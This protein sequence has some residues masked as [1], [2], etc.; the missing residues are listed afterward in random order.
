MEQQ[1]CCIAQGWQTAAYRQLI[2]RFRW[3]QH[4]NLAL[5]QQALRHSCLH[6]GLQHCRLLGVGVQHDRHATGIQSDQVVSVCLVLK[7]LYLLRR[8]LRLAHAVSSRL[9][10]AAPASAASSEMAVG[11]AEGP[12]HLREGCSK[13]Q[14]RRS[15]ACQ[16]YGVQPLCQL[17]QKWW[18]QALQGRNIG[19][20]QPLLICLRVA[21]ISEPSR[22]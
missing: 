1:P 21:D 2:G 14:P 5:L 17:H 16:A 6:K 13:A 4:T 19:W 7:P 22:A 11:T 18:P 20:L 9:A 10:N 3:S 8:E 12:H 15:W